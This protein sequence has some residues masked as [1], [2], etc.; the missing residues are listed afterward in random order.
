MT[1]SY[2]LQK[3]K[4]LPRRSLYATSPN[5]NSERINR[6][7]PNLASDFASYD[8]RNY[9]LLHGHRKLTEN[10]RHFRPAGTLSVRASERTR[11][12][13]TTERVTPAV[14]KS[15]RG[16]QKFS[17]ESLGSTCDCR[18]HSHK[19]KQLQ[20]FSKP[21]LTEEPWPGQTGG[22]EAEGKKGG[23]RK[24]GRKYDKKRFIPCDKHG[25]EVR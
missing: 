2:S 21:T 5:G 23:V 12:N 19:V 15:K 13:A 8:L 6:K 25:H 3:L 16:G 14:A 22:K 1:S 7:L 9:F 17:E 11:I 4:S 24:W 10:D 18:S 20:Q